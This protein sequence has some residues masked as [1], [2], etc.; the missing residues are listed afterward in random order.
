MANTTPSQDETLLARREAWIYAYRPGLRVTEQ[1]VVRSVG[2]GI[3]WIEGLPSAAMDDVLYLE[4][5]STALVFHLLQDQVGAILLHRSPALKSGVAAALSVQGL[6][7]PVSEGWLG[8]VIDPLGRPMDGPPAPEPAGRCL[9]FGPS[10]PITARDFVHKPLYTGNK[11]VDTLIPIAKGQRQ[12]LIGDNGVGKS[13]LALDTVVNQR[14][15]GVR[16]VYVLIGQKRSSAVQVIDTLRAH[17]AMEHSTVIVAEATE[18]PGLKYLAPFAG[19]ALAEW[20]MGQGRDTLVVY[21]DLTTHA[22]TYREL[23]LLLRRPPGREA[24][25]ADIFFLH[26]RLLE[27]STC[28]AP[29]FGGGSMTA[30]PLVETAQGDIATYIPTN[31]IS[32]TDG[33]V[34]LDARLFAAGALPAIDVSRS[35]SRI[36]GKGQHPRIKA[37]AGRM[38]LDYLQFLELEVFTR[39]GARLDPA[40]EAKI[41]RGRVLRTILKQGRLSPLPIEFQ[42]AWLV[43]FNQGLFDRAPLSEIPALMERLAT[44]VQQAGLALDDDVGRWEELVSTVLTQGAAR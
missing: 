16:C 36:G 11:I 37:Q 14:G 38:K 17:G 8:R 35:V 29:A 22:Q 10:P 30:L 43:G 15:T 6:S 34:Y 31:L 42:M 9:L 12:L 3:A 19:C 26:A 1:G 13:A 25:P 21:D 39:F 7:L 4:D 32:I 5:G 2:D 33:Q 28:L 24:Y 44:A 40:I 41:Q 23:S 18:L 27:R 20:W